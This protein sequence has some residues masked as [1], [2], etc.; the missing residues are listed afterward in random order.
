MKYKKG[1]KVRILKKESHPYSGYLYMDRNIIGKIGYI[2]EIVGGSYLINTNKSYTGY[3]G[4]FEEDEVEPVNEFQPFYVDCPTQEIWDKV[5]KKMFDM[6]YCWGAGDKEHRDYFSQ[7][8]RVLSVWDDGE[9]CH[10]TGI[11][12]KEKGFIKIP[13]Q[14]FLGE[15]VKEVK[16]R[17]FRVGDVVEVTNTD[18]GN[19]YGGREY[20]G[21]T[22]TI[23]ETGKYNDKTVYIL[24]PYTGYL[25]YDSELKLITP[26]EEKEE[27]PKMR[28]HAFTNVIWDE[29][30]EYSPSA[31]LKHVNPFYKLSKSLMSGFKKATAFIK[32][33]GEPLSTYYSLGWVELENDEF[34][35]TGEGKQALADFTLIG[36]AKTFEE[37]AKKELARRKKASRVKEEDED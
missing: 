35:T 15:E 16:E 8:N 33:L 23:T 13:Y 26:V 2:E 29:F 28:G 14:Q 24:S 19:F 21:V 5:E 17:A 31:P 6:G 32:R 22:F 18:G 10:G 30:T 36:G 4:L 11:V 7:N 9:I 27:K 12:P 37:Y 3:L 25:W 34:T 1:Q 20:I